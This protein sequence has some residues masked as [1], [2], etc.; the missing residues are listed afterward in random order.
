MFDEDI[1]LNGDSSTTP[2]TSEGSKTYSLV[3]LSNTGSRRS[4]SAL[5]NTNPQT[6]VISHQESNKGGVKRRRSLVRIDASVDDESKGSVP[7]ASYLVVDAPIGTDVT[8]DN[9]KAALGRLLAFVQTSG[10][11][12]K[13]LN[14]EP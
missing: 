3:S 13:I 1:A 8:T 14:G 7:Y 10:V 12:E 6:L 5:A 2:A 9:I 11:P 4:V